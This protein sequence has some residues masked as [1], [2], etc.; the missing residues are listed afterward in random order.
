[1]V[2]PAGFDGGPVG[3]GHVWTAGVQRAPEGSLPL[4]C[5]GG[6]HLRIA[7]PKGLTGGIVLIIHTM[8]PHRNMHSVCYL[9]LRPN[10]VRTFHAC[11]C[12]TCRCTSCSRTRNSSCSS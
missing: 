11:V 7:C 12:R 9:S 3:R 4:K 6:D 2:L 1:M 10:A 8:F 5:L